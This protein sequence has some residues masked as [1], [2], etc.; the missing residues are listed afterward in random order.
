[1]LQ[2]E[3]IFWLKPEVDGQKTAIINNDRETVSLFAAV[4]LEI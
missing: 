2:D 3:Q 4:Y 1:L